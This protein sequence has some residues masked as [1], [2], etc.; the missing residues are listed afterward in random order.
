VIVTLRGMTAAELWKEGKR[1]GGGG[2]IQEDLGRSGS[3]GAGV[4]IGVGQ[5]RVDEASRRV[6]IV[7]CWCLKV[8]LEMR[9]ATGL[10]S[11][12]VGV[13]GREAREKGRG[14]VMGAL[15][16]SKTALMLRN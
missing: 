5:R 4:G 10:G 3:R 9:L 15:A 16:C 8:S 11:S 12:S 2:P 14:G 13:C 7:S 1:A 6:S